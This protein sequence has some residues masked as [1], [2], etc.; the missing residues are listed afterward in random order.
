[1]GPTPAQGASTASGRRIV[2]P[3]A[4]TTALGAVVL[5]TRRRKMRIP[6]ALTTFSFVG[7]RGEPLKFKMLFKEKI[8]MKIAC[9]VGLL[10]LLPFTAC[11]QSSKSAGQKAS[12]PATPD[13]NADYTSYSCEQLHVAINAL[14]K[15][16]EELEPGE[17][18][19]AAARSGKP[20]PFTTKDMTPKQAEMLFVH[21]RMELCR[22]A[23]EEKNCTAGMPRPMHP[24]PA[25]PAKA[26]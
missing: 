15:R 20:L 10:L 4:P 11:A 1:M 3:F 14:G 24:G 2:L 18:V 13:Y 25:I 21:S 23:I 7:A 22:K 16:F 9:L 6:P 26:Q 5:C 12:Q 19:L 8:Y 17:A